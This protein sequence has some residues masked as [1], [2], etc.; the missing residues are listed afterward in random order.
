M[1]AHTMDLQLTFVDEIN[2]TETRN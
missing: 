2:H 1:A